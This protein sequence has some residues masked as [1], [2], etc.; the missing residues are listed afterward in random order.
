MWYNNT[1]TDRRLHGDV[2]RLAP[3]GHTIFQYAVARV[4]A[5]TYSFDRGA[6][7][8]FSN[9]VP[10]SPWPPGRRTPTTRPCVCVHDRARAR[11]RPSPPPSVAS[12]V[13]CSAHACSPPSTVRV[14]SVCACVWFFC[15]PRSRVCVRVCVRSCVLC[16]SVRPSVCSYRLFLY[17]PRVAPLRVRHPKEPPPRHVTTTGPLFSR[18]GNRTDALAHGNSTAGTLQPHRTHTSP[19]TYLIY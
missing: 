8:E 19:E 12:T 9:F 7:T 4:R 15:D 1:A 2:E 14:A 6:R 18:N 5:Y 11:A 3:H 10:F 13:C 17:Y 16:Q